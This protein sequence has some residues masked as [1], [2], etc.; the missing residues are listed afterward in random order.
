MNIKLT[1]GEFAVIQKLLFKECGISLNDTK[2]IMVEA[3]LYKR[4]EYYK[5]ISY[6]DYLKIVQIS[7][8]EKNEFLNALSTNETYFFREEKHFEFLTA[9]SKNSNKLH[10]WSAAASMGA[11][12]YTIAMILDTYLEKDCCFYIA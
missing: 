12:A 10:I 4:I 11:E 2:Q 8:V 3:R 6:A 7:K 9:L 5:V 1:Q